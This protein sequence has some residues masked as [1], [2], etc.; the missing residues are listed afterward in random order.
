MRAS[1]TS[2]IS[3]RGSR[4]VFSR[5]VGLPPQAPM[6]VFALAR[7]AGWVAHVLEQ[8]AHGSLLRPRARFETPVA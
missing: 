4:P 1:T 8:R 3:W 5:M 7:T 2:A 6:A